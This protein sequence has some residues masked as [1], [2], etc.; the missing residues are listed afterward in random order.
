MRELCYAFI[1]IIRR[2]FLA[3]VIKQLRCGLMT[4]LAYKHWAVISMRW[5]ACNSSTLGWSV[6][7]WI[8]L[9][10]SGIWGLAIVSRSLIG[11]LLKVTP[12]L[13][14]GWNGE[15][16]SPLKSTRLFIPSLC[17]QVDRWKV[18]SAS[19]D[20]TIKVWSLETGKRLVT[21]KNHTDG[22]TCLQFNDYV[23]VSGSYDK[24][25]KLW[26]FSCC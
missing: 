22:V 26:D 11:K 5:L 18:V 8:A 10:D 25:V 6:A 20:K 17:L 21:L 16:F 4:A 15:G 9:F 24:T 2:S 1:L 13:S 14:G 23:I 19:D 3:Q 12:E 7:R